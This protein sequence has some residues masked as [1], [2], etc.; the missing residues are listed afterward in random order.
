MRPISFVLLVCL[1][2]CAPSRP[3]LAPTAVPALAD[4]AAERGLGKVVAVTGVVA[5]VKTRAQHGFAYLNFGAPYPGQ[6]F[7]VLIPDSATA[8]FG[9]L[10]RL[11]GRRATATGRVWLQDGRWPAM[12]LTDPAALVVAP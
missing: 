10:E 2:G 1:L 4:T 8:R 5:Q 11:T 12:T 6:S 9:D 7:S 3:E